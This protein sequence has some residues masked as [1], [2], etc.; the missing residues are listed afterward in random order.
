MAKKKTGKK[1]AKKSTKKTTTKKSVKKEVVETP[2]V[3]A[4]TEVKP[5]DKTHKKKI[6][7]NEK[8]TTPKNEETVPEKPKT[9]IACGDGKVLEITKDEE[10]E[11]LISKD[12]LIIAKFF[13]TWC[14]CCQAMAPIVRIYYNFK[15]YFIFIV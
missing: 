5:V 14:G 13:A 6:L 9:S 3:E 4:Q 15:I 1:T 11:E 8:S 7:E 12:K 10:F 2:V